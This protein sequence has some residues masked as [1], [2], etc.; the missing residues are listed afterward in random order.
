MIKV[1]TSGW[2]R[3]ELESRGVNVRGKAISDA[4]M[5]RMLREI[6]VEVYSSRKEAGLSAD[7]ETSRKTKPKN[8]NQGELF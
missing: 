3:L 6:G 5:A 7:R 1:P 2:M 8:K 4:D